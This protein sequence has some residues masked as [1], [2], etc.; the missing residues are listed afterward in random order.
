MCYFSSKWCVL[1]LFCCCCFLENLDVEVDEDEEVESPQ[2]EERPQATGKVGAKK[3]RKL[4]EK[5]A[6][7]AQREVGDYGHLT[8]FAL[9]SDKTAIF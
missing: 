2:A 7:R 9:A 5:Q 6:R 3:Q 8:V 1:C 4:E